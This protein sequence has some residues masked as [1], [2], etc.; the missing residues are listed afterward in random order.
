MSKVII[1]I[2]GGELD[3]A[4]GIGFGINYAIDDVN[5]PEKK[6]SNHSKTITLAGTKNNNKQLGGLFDIN[7]DFTFFN[8]NIKVDAKI[9]IDSSTVLDGYMQLK[10]IEKASNTYIDGNNIQYKA[11]MY[12]RSTDFY[13]DIK[14]KNLSI[15]DFSRFNHT[16]SKANIEASWTNTPAD[17][18]TYPLL[19]KN[20]N[21]YVT[22]D[23]K[24]A[25][26][27]K[28]YLKRIAQEAGYTLG[29]TL[30]DTSTD[31]GAAYAKEI[32]PFNGDIP[33]ISDAEYNRRLFEAGMGSAYD[34]MGS[35][36]IL[37]GIE[38]GN[39]AGFTKAITPFTSF[40]D[41]TTPPFNDANGHWNTTTNEYTVDVDGSYGI[42]WR[43]G[44]SA[45]VTNKRNISTITNNGGTKIF[46]NFTANHG[47]PTGVSTQVTVAGTVNYD[48]TY[49][50]TYVDADTLTVTV[51]YVSDEAVGTVGIDA[52][53][54]TYREDF[55]GYP[56][57]ETSEGAYKI[58]V[59]FLLQKNGINISVKSRLITLNDNLLAGNDWTDTIAANVEWDIP[60]LSLLDTDVLQMKYQVLN[61]NGSTK[62]VYANTNSSLSSAK[63]I[64]VD[65]DFG[66]VPTF[67]ASAN[68]G[69]I[70]S[71]NPSDITDGDTININEYIPANIKQSD[72]ITDLVKRYNAYI[73]VDEDNDRKIIIDT[74]DSYYAKGGTLDWTNKKD[75]NYRDKI[76]LLSELQKKELIFT[77]KSDKDDFNENYTKSV[78]G[79]IYGQKTIEFNNE[80]V[81]G[82]NKI[83]TPFSPTPLIYN[84]QNPVAIVPAINTLEPQTNMR[85]LYFDGVINCI[86]GGSWSLGWT[87][88]GTPNTTTYTTY[89]YA[90][91]YDN[92]LTPSLDLN[93]G[94]IP[95]AW[96]SEATNSTNGDLYNRY[97]ANYVNQIDDGKLV[98]MQINLTSVDIANIKNNLNS[99]IFI[100]DSYYY[101]NKIKDYNP[102]NKG[103]TIVEF[104]KI[105][106]GISFVSEQDDTGVTPSP[107]EVLRKSQESTNDS[108]STNTTESG[109]SILE[110]CNNILSVDSEYA[111]VVGCDN[112]VS[113][114]SP[115]AVILGNNNLIGN[116][117]DNGFII[118][119][120]NKTVL[121][122]GEGWIGETHFLNGLIVAEDAELTL[123]EL[124]TKRDA[125]EL[126]P[127]SWYYAYDKGFYFFA[128]QDSLLS[129]SG[130]RVMSIIKNTYYGSLGIFVQATSYALNDKIIW[131]GRVWNCILAGVSASSSSIALNPTNWEVDLSSTYYEDKIFDV[132]YSEDLSLVL[133]Q[134]DERGN[135]VTVGK[136]SGSPIAFL[137]YVNGDGFLYSDWGDTRINGNTC[138]CFI[139]N[140][141]S[142]ILGNNCGGIINNTNDITNNDIA[143][144]IIYNSCSVVDN[145]NVG[146]IYNNSITNTIRYNCNIG[147]IKD[148][149]ND[150]FIQSNINNGNIDNNSNIGSITENGN[151]G[152]ITDNTSNALT[153]F[154]ISQNMNSGFINFNNSTANITI[155]NNINNGYIG[156]GVLTNRAVSITDTTVN[157]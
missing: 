77:Y 40:D 45:S 84:S 7:A 14:G 29:G 2:A 51:A 75:Y 145:N 36:T 110:G 152:D 116:D 85:V 37:G 103:L 113:D 66:A 139:N 58:L 144:D 143:N 28:A 3:L 61:N 147:D 22:K 94:Y 130:K 70:N 24:P 64:G 62:I 34:S 72:I 8:P 50:A 49:A 126:T 59:Y 95:Y 4:E 16:Y 111:L 122:S 125:G 81:K 104:L 9:I 154:S 41:D 99:K 148:N 11:V 131:G 149:S 150:G 119:T 101:I 12:S 146:S 46:L 140:D 124:I 63:G 123:A 117:V 137:S 115:N 27:H 19:Y 98:T 82:E 108:R 97:W 52:Y 156:A 68:S 32:I 23:F 155:N 54:S 157:K 109:D 83:E 132:G 44:L 112:V 134:R 121:E 15:L 106:D 6:N 39:Y 100:R 120:N 135:I 33:L 57:D 138:A 43:I 13:S 86:N 10:S 56:V 102:I 128:L 17:V 141:T 60:A 31:E 18:Y 25:I 71:V 26:Y 136:T 133:H 76:E 142:S 92:P 90:G 93:F 87:S 153:T 21:A 1:E 67:T 53:Q 5:N 35:D 69:V 30:M 78:D 96:Y 55:W 89:P 48:G 79:D 65:F 80:F 118:G 129:F 91:H 88:A 151:L 74:R 47:V 42:N 105:T 38:N 20:S 127:L 73:S 107:F 114:N